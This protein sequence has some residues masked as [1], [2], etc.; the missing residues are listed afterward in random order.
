MAKKTKPTRT[1]EGITYNPERLNDPNLRCYECEEKHD[2][3][4]KSDYSAFVEKVKVLG[5]PDLFSGDCSRLRDMITQK[6]SK[7]EKGMHS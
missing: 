6:V 5:I 4:Y 7:F 1:D 3:T 2:A